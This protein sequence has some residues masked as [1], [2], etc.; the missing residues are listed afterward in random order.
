MAFLAKVLTAVLEY[1]IAQAFALGVKQY[2][3]LEADEAI[4]KQAELDSQALASAKDSAE[5]VAALEK[6]THDTFDTSIKS[7]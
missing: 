7:K 1:I 4:K 2:Q 3:A 6:I 5:R